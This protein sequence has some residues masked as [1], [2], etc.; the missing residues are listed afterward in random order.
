[1]NF[2]YPKGQQLTEV[3]KIIFL[4]LYDI[5]VD[6]YG[7]KIADANVQEESTYSKEYKLAWEWALSMPKKERKQKYDSL[8]IDKRQPCT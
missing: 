3:H 8:K 4:I 5:L 1:M 6:L 7:K 2:D